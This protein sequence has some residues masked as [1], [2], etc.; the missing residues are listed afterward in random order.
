M[1]KQPPPPT[2]GERLRAVLD[3]LGVSQ[4]ELARRLEVA[5]PQ[6]WRWCNDD[7]EPQWSQVDRI[8]TALGVS[9]EEFRGG[10]K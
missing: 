2:F 8:A 3:R 6:V 9:T 7:R 5:V 1:V 4:S 10:G